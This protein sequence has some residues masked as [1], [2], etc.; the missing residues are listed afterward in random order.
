M[1]R[2]SH[3]SNNQLSLEQRPSLTSSSD[4][5]AA[6]PLTQRDLLIVVFASSLWLWAASAARLSLSKSGQPCGDRLAR[7]RTLVGQPAINDQC[8]GRGT[9]FWG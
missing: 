5:R 7:T 3:S 2:D 8:R 9:N 1:D 6:A 4:Q